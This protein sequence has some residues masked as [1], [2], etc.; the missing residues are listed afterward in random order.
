MLANTAPGRVIASGDGLRLTPSDYGA[1]LERLTRD[2]KLEAD[3]YSRGG[4]V[5]QLERRMASALGKESAVYFPT[6]T[7]ANHFA[8]RALAGDRRRVLIQA[9]SHLYNDSG[10]CAQSLS[11]L[12]LVPLAPGRAAFTAADVEQH[13]ERAR[14]SRVD[15]PVGAVVIESPVRR[16]RG[17]VFPIDEMRRV[18]EAAR[19][20]GVGLH[21][22]GARLFLATAYTG[23]SARD[24]SDL[25]DTVYVSLYKYFNAPAGAILAGPRKLLDNAYH[26]RR[27]F[28]GGVNQSWP[29]AA[30]ALHYFDGFERRFASAVKAS[31]AV[32]SALE[33]DGGFAV[34]RVP[35]GTNVWTL[36]VAGDADRL[37]KRLG[38]DGIDLPA[39]V[40][41]KF[42][43]GVNE[44]WT[45]IEPSRIAGLFVAAR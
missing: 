16:M 5:E 20:H 35:N 3:S 26:A 41:G 9:E 37:R 34:G 36:G 28:G 22:D 21:L 44:S 43:L 10:D 24:Y 8:A 2:G 40:E 23:V 30:V 32:K 7:L 12:N 45:R 33:K 27:M 15:V 13:I 11:N 6:G 14:G 4:V 17:E 31:E 42:T 39:P 38:A 19:R 1:L 25:F 29:N 18:C